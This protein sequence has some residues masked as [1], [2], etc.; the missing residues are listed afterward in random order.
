[1]VYCKSA[2]SYIR[3]EFSLSVFTVWGLLQEYSTLAQGLL[4]ALIVRSFADTILVVVSLCSCFSHVGRQGGR[5]NVSIGPMCEFKGVV[6]HEVFHSL[7]RWHEH[8][9]ADRDS[10]VKVNMSVFSAEVVLG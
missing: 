4:I 5:Q 1:M 7:G 3:G 9:R 2:C 8:S 10:Y 6:I